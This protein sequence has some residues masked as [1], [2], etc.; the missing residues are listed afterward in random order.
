M[1][2]FILSIVSLFFIF[3]IKKPMG[4]L[5]AIFALIIALIQIKKKKTL[6]YIGLILAIFAIIYSIFATVIASK[7]VTS[8][9]DKSK[10]K[11]YTQIE[12]DLAKGALITVEQYE[13]ECAESES[14]CALPPL[15]EENL[16][17]A[18]NY[19]NFKSTLK[20]CDGYIEIKYEDLKWNAKTYLNCPDYQTDGYKFK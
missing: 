13:D 6:N 12:E 5:F 4:I 19:E 11:A 2:S 14:N 8:V 3:V 1:L 9:V 20:N 17:Y 7:S 18:Y 15:L 10:E 16:D